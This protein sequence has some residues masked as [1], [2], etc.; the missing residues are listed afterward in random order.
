MTKEKRGVDL[1]EGSV[2]K[3]LLLYFLPILAGSL[4]QQLYSTVD[5]V[6]LGQFAGKTGLAAIDAVYSFLK[7][8]VNFFVGL[9]AGT[10][11]LISQFFGAR[12]NSSLS[13]AVHTG[14]CFALA[15]GLALSVLGFLVAPLC[16]KAME[17]PRELFDL[18][19]SYV[20][21]L[22]GGFALSMLY[23]VGA[24]ILRAVGDSKTPF[25]VLIAAG[26]ANV[27]LDLVLV[28]IF[29]MNAPGAALATVF[30]QG[31]SAAL[32]LRVLLRTRA[33]Y[34]V[35]G[36]E[37]RIDKAMLHSICRIGLPVGL[38]S[39]L[40]P[41]ANMMV[42]SGINRTGTDNI[43]AWALCGKLDFMIWLIAD[44]LS[45]AVSTFVAQNHGA[46]KYARTRYGV[47]VGL[48]M[49][50]GFI[51]L[52]SAA[53][54]FGSVSLGRLLIN[55]ADLNIAFEAGRIMHFLA[56]LYCLY[57]IGEVYAGAI[58]GTGETFRPMLITLLGTCATRILWILFVVP[59]HPGFYTI[60][61]CY[62]VSW[63]VT[64]VAFFLYYQAHQR[65]A[66]ALRS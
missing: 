59:R 50:V 1:T 23:N 31:L 61:G 28:A 53:L 47:R 49:T 22:F 5:A 62:P 44:S 12:D 33:P 65:R 36:A 45:E 21:I 54:F 10:T 42:Q 40:Y 63:A 20:R 38:Q 56:P 30:A 32:V 7:L 18:S 3:R 17:V 8:P 34:R 4:F 51:A 64:A 2:G 11:I 43:A 19:L 9:S 6:I 14:I 29:K 66:P 55:P 16:L 41:V 25:Y 24:G 37:L 57:A 60:L 58:R 35:S 48:F 26:G 52:I 27:V 15:G 46:G 39:A 13:K